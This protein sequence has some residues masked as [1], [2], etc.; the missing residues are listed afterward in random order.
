MYL[1]AG[2][3]HMVANRDSAVIEKQVH[4]TN[5]IFTPDDHAALIKNSVKW[6]AFC[7]DPDAATELQDWEIME[8]LQPRGMP[9]KRGCCY[10]CL[11][12]AYTEGYGWGSSYCLYKSW[13]D[14]LVSLVKGIGDSAVGAFSLFNLPVSRMY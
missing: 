11:S 3:K 13:T 14:V 12:S 9:P 5:Y 7:C 8:N 1:Q 4:E 10:F 2:Q 6:Q